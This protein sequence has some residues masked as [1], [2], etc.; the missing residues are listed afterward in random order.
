MK[1]SDSGPIFLKID[2]WKIPVFICGFCE[3]RLV[4]VTIYLVS[5]TQKHWRPLFLFHFYIFVVDVFYLNS[6]NDDKNLKNKTEKSRETKKKFKFATEFD[7]KRWIKMAYVGTPCYWSFI[8]LETDKDPNSSQY[9]MLVPIWQGKD[10]Q[11]GINGKP[12]TEG[13]MGL[14]GDRGSNGLPGIPGAQVN[15]VP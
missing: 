11:P 8:N 15:F 3:G 4:F 5:S 7:P 13:E 9:F 2:E 14:Q 10:G 6:A 1:T 12:G